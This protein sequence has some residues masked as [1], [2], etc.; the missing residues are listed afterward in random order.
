MQIKFFL[1]LFLKY[2]SLLY[3][4][5]GREERKESEREKEEGERRI[6]IGRA[7]RVKE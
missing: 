4:K 1:L 5:E 2:F 7:E 6:C 3:E